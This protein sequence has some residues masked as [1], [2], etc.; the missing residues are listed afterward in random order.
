M[1]PWIA[2]FLCAV[3]GI[4]TMHIIANISVRRNEKR[5]KVHARKIAISINEKCALILK[6]CNEKRQIT[7]SLLKDVEGILEECIDAGLIFYEDVYFEF[8]AVSE[9]IEFIENINPNDYTHEQIYRIGKMHSLLKI[10]KI[11]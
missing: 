11:L 5:R 6:L 1:I 7:D 8:D 9:L 10:Y 2:A 4:V 3:L